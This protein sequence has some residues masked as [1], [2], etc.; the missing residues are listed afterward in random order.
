MS[1][2]A[3]HA[4]TDAPS[5][6][7]DFL[8]WLLLGLAV[9]VLLFVVATGL[10]WKRRPPPSEAAPAS[11]ARSPKPV[12][13]HATTRD[14]AVLTFD[15]LGT[16]ERAFGRVRDDARGEPWLM[17]VAFAERHRHERLVVRGTFA[18]RYLDIGDAGG[19]EHPAG[20]LFDEIRDNVPVGLSAVVMFGPTD[21]VDEMVGAFEGSGGHLARRR[22][23]DA[24]ATK[25][26]AS[27]AD[28]PRAAEPSL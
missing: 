27:V 3:V 10:R 2:L 24:E 25:L 11:S 5:A 7:N 22:V 14:I 1:P 12:R 13:E 17:E 16:A 15:G 28:A 8:P 18:G 26:E 20:A 19:Q 21:D 23:S 9:F 4:A 6:W